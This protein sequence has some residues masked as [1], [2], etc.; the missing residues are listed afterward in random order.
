M[1]F[2]RFRYHSDEYL[3]QTIVSTA[4]TVKNVDMVIDPISDHMGGIR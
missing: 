1:Y 3:T 4:T 2:S